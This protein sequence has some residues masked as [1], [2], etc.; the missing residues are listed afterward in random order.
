[1]N[2]TNSMWPSVGNKQGWNA[3]IVPPEYIYEGRKGEKA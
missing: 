3:N 1:M 2:E